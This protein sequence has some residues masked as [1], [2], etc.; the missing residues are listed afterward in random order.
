M[1]SLR[2]SSIGL[3]VLVALA[4]FVAPTVQSAETRLVAVDVDLASRAVVV[5]V[6]NTGTT[7]AKALVTVTALV[8]GLPT[9]SSAE[10]TVAAGGTANVQVGFP[11][12]VSSVIVVGIIE[13]NDPIS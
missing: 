9:I 12:D 13:A 1:G 11:G 4:S 10:A 8:N 7:S 3:A 2:R 5:S 6:E